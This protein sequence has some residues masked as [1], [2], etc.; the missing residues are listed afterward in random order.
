LQEN[1]LD[2]YNAEKK[3]G[4]WDYFMKTTLRYA[5]ED[6]PLEIDATPGF[7]GIP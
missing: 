3:R 5:T 7:V 2:R 4:G 1:N 6:L